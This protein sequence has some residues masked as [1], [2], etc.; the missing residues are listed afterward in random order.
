MVRWR[1]PPEFS[2]TDQPPLAAVAALAAAVA[3]ADGVADGDAEVD[4]EGLDDGFADD[5]ADGWEVARADGREVARADGRVAGFEGAGWVLGGACVG[6]D[7][8]GAAGVL[9]EASAVGD[10]VGEDDGLTVVGGAVTTYVADWVDA[11][12]GRSSER[13]RYEVVAVGVTVTL[14]SVVLASITRTGVQ[15]PVPTLSSST[16]TPPGTRAP[17]LSRS[18]PVRVTES[19]ACTVL[20]LPEIETCVSSPSRS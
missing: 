14:G 2:R 17:V 7:D 20:A 6:G 4:G 11:A 15:S 13:K 16:S 1:A 5:V 8:V 9:G 12:S 10:G 18:A 19:P 3:P